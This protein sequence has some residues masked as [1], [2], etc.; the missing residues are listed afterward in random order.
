M[1]AIDDAIAAIDSREE[2]ASFSYRKV[3]AQFKVNRITLA[4][5]HQGL[6]ATRA[7]KSQNQQSLS[8]QQELELV[9]YIE[10]LTER[11]L[12]PTR[13]MIQNFASSVVDKPV[14]SAWVSRFLHRNHHLVTPKWTTGIDRQ[15]HKADSEVKYRQYFDL[16]HYKMQEYDIEP[17]NTYNIDEKGFLIG[18][19]SRTKQV[20]SKRL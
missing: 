15:R 17:E 19:T 2:G 14:S 5:R 18:I 6:Q 16:L 12:P 8:P 3:A 20:F 7:A 11:G 10:G 1:T 4:R 9:Q 13:T